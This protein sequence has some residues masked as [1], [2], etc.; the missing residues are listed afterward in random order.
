MPG[1]P[2]S[3]ERIMTWYKNAKLWSFVGGAAAMLVGQAVA[4]SKA[5]RKLAVNTVA[6]SMLIKESCHEAMQSVK[7]DAEDV[8]ADARARTREKAHEDARR[9]EIE[10]RVRR[11]VEA[12]YAAQEEADAAEDAGDAGAATETKGAGKQVDAKAGAA[13][14]GAAKAS[15]AA[16]RSRK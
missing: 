12:E 16:G 3:E 5:C 14:S 13:K 10:E 15:G 4:K 11:E 2:T 6:Q 8:A 7:D 9:A 1:R